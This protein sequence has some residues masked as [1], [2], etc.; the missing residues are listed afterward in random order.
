MAMLKPM[1][2]KP[3]KTHRD[4]PRG[5]GRYSAARQH[6]PNAYQTYRRSRRPRFLIDGTRHWFAV[7]PP[8]RSRSKAEKRLN[9][10]GRSLGFV[11]HRHTEPVVVIRRN[12]VVDAE[13]EPCAGYLFLGVRAET[14]LAAR[15]ILAAYRDR[16]VLAERPEPFT[17][18]LGPIPAE[19]LQRF[20]DTLLGYTKAGEPLVI[21]IPP[22]FE[23]GD[24]V[25]V[26]EGP[27]AD[28]P[29]QVEEVDDDR[30]RLK[31]AVNIFGRA[32]PVELEYRQ[33]E[34]T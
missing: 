28:F 34:K 3:N 8:D 7:R 12:R 2:K 19:Q 4:S 27:F 6:V 16:E 24:V 33:V 31:V 32:T 26:T 30:A 11:A 22:P 20:A 21:V 1:P 9:D 29:G 5:Q 23:I 14:E 17:E 13:T 10:A 18:V 15:E 25:R